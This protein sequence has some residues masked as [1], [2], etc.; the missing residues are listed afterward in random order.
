[1]DQ[2]ISCGKEVHND[3]IVFISLKC[4]DSRNDESIFDLDVLGMI[5]AP[6]LSF[7][8]PTIQACLALV[9]GQGPNYLRA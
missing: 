8:R 2:D 9:V 3:H 4:V 5:L 7:D 1:M 6:L